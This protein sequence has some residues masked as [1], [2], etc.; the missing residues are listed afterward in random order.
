M[1]RIPRNDRILS[2][3]HNDLDGAGCGILLGAIFPNITYVNCSYYDIDKELQATNP[4]D[5]DFIFVT[6]IFPNDQ[7]SLEK[8]D[9]LIL[10]DH[11]QTAENRPEN[12]WYVNKKYSATYLTKHFLEK[13]YGVDSLKSYTKLVK[14]I[15]DYDLWERKYKGSSALNN[16]F[17]LY[18]SEKFRERFRSGDIEFN[19]REKEHIKDIQKRFD[20][21]YDNLEIFEFEKINACFFIS[22]I[23]VNELSDKLL[24]TDGYDI[25]FFNTLKNYK[26]SIRSK[27]DDF[28]VGMYLKEKNIGG[29]HFKAA[30][31]DVATE[32]DMNSTLDTLEKD[33]YNLLP[34]IR[35]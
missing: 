31:I 5:Y 28:N 9:N 29:G 19:D 8:F 34:H 14:L 35:K 32:H 23:S 26:I 18:H 21:L 6:D 4:V 22:D 7:K 10:I 3:S 24:H 17:S 2:I 25:V 33:L 12:K 1:T 16:L 20:V 30:G 13:M 27:L 11:H 15:N